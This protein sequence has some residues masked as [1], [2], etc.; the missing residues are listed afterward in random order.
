MSAY[1]S[2]N[3]IHNM[4]Q[5]D[6]ENYEENARCVVEVN[7]NVESSDG[8]EANTDGQPN[9]DGA[10]HVVDENINAESIDG[11]D[12]NTNA[13]SNE[14]HLQDAN[15]NV[16]AYGVNKQIQMRRPAT[17]IGYTT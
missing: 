9:E 7:F 12:A 6:C 14:A 16:Q 13:Q 5:K 3:Y 1:E 10:N 11:H 8:H 17:S 15:T 2:R 4:I